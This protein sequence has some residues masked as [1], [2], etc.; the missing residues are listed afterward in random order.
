MI[1]FDQIRLFVLILDVHLHSKVVVCYV[2]TWAVWRKFGNYDL[3]DKFDPDLC[4]HLIYSFAGLNNETNEIKSLDPW[5]DLEDNYGKGVLIILAESA[6][7]SVN[8]AN[9]CFEFVSR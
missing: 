4:T 2:G 7:N 3:L 1:S 6:E 9:L 5:L 8:S